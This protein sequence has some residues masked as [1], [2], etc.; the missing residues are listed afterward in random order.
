MNKELLARGTHVDLRPVPG[1][2]VD[3][4]DGEYWGD[5]RAVDAAFLAELLTRPNGS[6][7]GTHRAVWLAGA[8]VTGAL[9]LEAAHL[10]RPL[11]LEDC[12]FES[13][14]PVL[15]N[16][17]RAFTVQ[18]P[19]C[20]VPGF[21][22]NCLQTQGDV[23]LGKGFTATGEVQVCGAHIQG[24][25]DC[26]DGVF[27]N[28]GGTAVDAS[29]MIADGGIWFEGARVTG[30][31]DLVSARTGGQLNCTNGAFDNRA[32]GDENPTALRAY[33][34]AV[35]DSVFL[36][37]EKG[38]EFE[39][40][41]EVVLRNAQIGGDLDCS[42]GRF[43]HAGGHSEG[44]AIDAYAMTCAGTVL[45]HEDFTAHGGVML[46]GARVG[47]NLQ[48]RKGTFISA[49]ESVLA[50][51]AQCVAVDGNVNLRE[52]FDARGGVSFL[53]ARVGGDLSCTGGQFRRGPG[54]SK[55]ALRLLGA[56]ITR[57]VRFLPTHVD[58]IV[59]LRMT[60]VGGW[61]DA[62]KSWDDD[63]QVR[64]NG[65][66]YT[67]IDGMEQP[68]PVRRHLAWPARDTDGMEPSM[69][70]RRR[71]AWLA[72][73]IDGFAPQPYRQL[74]DVYQ[75]EGNERDARRV[76][77]AAQLRR[78]DRPH[79]VFGRLQWPFRMAWTGMLW[80]TVGFGYRPWR[81][82]LPIGGLYCLGWWLFDRAAG[83]GQIHRSKTVSSEVDFHSG[84]YAADLLIPGAG[85]GERARFY[86]VGDAANYASFYTLAGWALAAMLIAG[87]T[88]VFKRL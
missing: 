57:R 88:G 86:A 18:L 49:T 75:R 39:A 46:H 6:D 77:V 40:Y 11:H 35:A 47:G 58:G 65:F 56:D 74:A 54:S 5:E 62:A 60:K 22:A 59:D 68:T 24:A 66:T 37:T 15:M 50:L 48:C 23:C 53:N 69:P 30:L 7:G 80:A 2:R 28:A 72:R 44:R 76:R 45:C 84:R 73:D 1:E 14:E 19:G 70:V 63:S 34:I 27:H 4:G 85:L 43:H 36:R 79:R 9:D 67:S 71:L 31:L 51:D 13:P 17:A 32:A 87:L 78:R 38:G 20:H 33:G 25:L 3:A 10:S 42:G 52:G 12:Y 81:I 83:L 61:Q 29:G 55:Y 41:G 8:R 21:H 26:D 16:D 82:L 64:L